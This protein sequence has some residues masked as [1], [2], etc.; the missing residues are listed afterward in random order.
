MKLFKFLIILFFLNSCSFDNKTGIWNNE[1]KIS[2]DKQ[3]QIFKDFKKISSSIK[4]FN[5]NIPL[6]KN[7]K[8]NLDKSVNNVSWQDY[9]FDSNNNLKNFKYDNLNQVVLKSKKL[10]KYELNDYFLY[11]N[12]NVI[13]NDLKG[14]LIVYSLTEKSIITKFNFYK[15]KYKKIKKLLNLIV[16]GD[17]IYVSDNIGYIYAYNY[18]I[19]QI[20]WAKNYKIPFRSNLK[21]FSNQIVASNQNNDLFIFN[22]ISGNLK[23][24]IPS[25]ETPINNSFINNIVLNENNIIFL[26]TFGSLYSVNKNNFNFNWF[27]NLNETLDLNISNL[28]IGS[29]VVCNKDKIFLSSKNNFYILQS[30]NGR[31]V[32][33]KNFSSELRPIIYMDYIFLITKNNF[34]LAMNASNGKIIYS[35][36]IKE[37]VADLFN[38]DK[39]KLEIKNFMLVN[40]N[41]YIFL[42]NGNVIQLD[43]RGE[44]NQIIKLP[45]T[46]DSFPIIVD[47]LLL[48]LNKKN[49]LILLN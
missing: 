18:K 42:K 4:T 28:Y 35:Y 7:F 11:N 13:L 27:L 26:N 31:V 32:A 20:I 34:L 3:N 17:I 14:N 49:K 43:I 33:K 45:S 37:K 6:K 44:I 47:R 12:N 36:D 40:G 38:F 39:K 23:K 25:E 46:L 1:N 22:K 8:F 16:E 9:Y 30:K 24:L 15:K 2:D 29:K 10:S 5:E 19:N 41:I 48:Y 21:L